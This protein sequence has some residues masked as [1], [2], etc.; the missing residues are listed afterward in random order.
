D[1][2]VGLPDRVRQVELL[3][4]LLAEAHLLLPPVDV[5]RQQRLEVARLEGHAVE[6]ELVRGRDDTD[7]GR[8]ALDLALLE[9]PEPQQ[10]TH[11][12]A[13]A[14]PQE[15]AVAAPLEP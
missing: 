10:R 12:V 2:L 6:V 8:V 15:V 11:V 5:N 7:G 13:V 4:V 9:L 1:P 3:E 14:V